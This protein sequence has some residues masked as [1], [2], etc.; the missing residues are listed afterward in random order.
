M[1]KTEKINK[2]RE[3]LHK[4]PIGS[5]I[6]DFD[7]LKFLQSI[8]E[9]HSEWNLKKGVGI[10]FITVEFTAYKNKCFFIHRIDKICCSFLS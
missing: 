7:E 8:F 1:K 3:I 10:D 5:K 4:Y 6:S 9:G 2:C